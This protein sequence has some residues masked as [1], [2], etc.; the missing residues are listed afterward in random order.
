MKLLKKCLILV[1]AVIIS[2]SLT[3][4]FDFG[5]STGGN[6]NTPSNPSTP[7]DSTLDFDFDPSSMVSQPQINA[8]A[9]IYMPE[10]ETDIGDANKTARTN[11]YNG[12]I[13]AV[14]KAFPEISAP[15]GEQTETDA[16]KK[17]RLINNKKNALIKD[18]T[19]ININGYLT[20]AENVEQFKI[21]L[22]ESEIENLVNFIVTTFNALAE[23]DRTVSYN[24]G[25][26]TKT[27][28]ITLTDADKT[29]IKNEI[30][31]YLSKPENIP[32]GTQVIGGTT[33]VFVAPMVEVAVY[34]VETYQIEQD[35]G[36]GINTPMDI[37]YLDDGKGYSTRSMGEDDFS[38]K[39]ILP[40][41]KWLSL[42]YDV[43]PPSSNKIFMLGFSAYIVYKNDD[44]VNDIESLI[45]RQK[46]K[47]Y[48]AV[49]T[50]KS[51]TNTIELSTSTYYQ[52]VT[53]YVP[54]DIQND[55]DRM[56]EENPD[57]ELSD[58]DREKMEEKYNKLNTHFAGQFQVEINCIDETKE[59][60]HKAPTF[61]KIEFGNI[62]DSGIYKNQY[63][64]KQNEPNEKPTLQFT[65]NTIDNA[66]FIHFVSTDENR[67]AFSMEGVDLGVSDRDTFDTTSSIPGL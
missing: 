56:K 9:G 13:S 65:N 25:G 51:S 57:F 48:S 46:L 55:V 12:V 11:V 34:N 6:P 3:G 28:V 15:T 60:G 31:E 53:D 36:G 42:L 64:Y 32:G 40:Q 47:N 22:F 2:F 52:N 43:E 19:K 67:M 58:E 10:S 24:E 44:G 45:E 8:I 66:M 63:Q 7:S 59:E 61:E 26:E 49:I 20:N 4:C 27:E 37:K 39:M 14:A 35:M 41:K 23:A 50:G 16:Q 18:S 17:T 29:T 62:I 21:G 38:D 30:V 54:L 1:F 33:A 5:G